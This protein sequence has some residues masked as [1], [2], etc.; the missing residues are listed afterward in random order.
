MAVNQGYLNRATTA[1][2]RGDCRTAINAA[3]DAVGVVSVRADPFEILAY[4][5][6][7]SRAFPLALRAMEAAER[8][9]PGNWQ[10]TYGLALTRAL[11]GRDPRPAAALALRQNPMDRLAQDL[12]KQFREAGRSKR[13]WLRVAARADIPRR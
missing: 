2:D 8:R 3:L 6:T 9:D 11:V 12:D 4:C 10:Y 7:R 1:F 5:D 13:R